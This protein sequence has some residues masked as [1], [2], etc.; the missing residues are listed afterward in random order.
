MSYDDAYA[1]L[2]THEARLEHNQIAKYVF[3]ANYGMVN[4]NYSLGRD[5]GR[6]RGYGCSRYHGHFNVG[7]MNHYGGRGMF[8]H[9]YS[10]GFPNDNG[11]YNLARGYSPQMPIHK[12]SSHNKS[13]FNMSYDSFT[14][15][16]SDNALIC[17]ICHKSSHT[18]DACWH[19]YTKNYIAPVRSFGR[20]R[21][22]KAAYMTNFEPFTEFGPYI[23][24]SHAMN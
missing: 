22:S 24:N 6:R 14:D 8:F 20:V 2:L 21:G 5:S 23:A 10:K 19:R 17:Q 1:L 16:S 4:S 11:S 18:A 15:E 12:A 3:N 9:A 7:N 13:V